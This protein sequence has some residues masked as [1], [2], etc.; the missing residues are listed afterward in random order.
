MV[1]GL[2]LVVGLAAW[3]VVV[4]RPPADPWPMGA[5]LLGVTGTVLIAYLTTREWPLVV[6]VLVAVSPLVAIVGYGRSPFGEGPLGYGNASGTL[7]LLAAAGALT[8]ARSVTQRSLRVVLHVAAG[9]WMVSPLAVM[10]DTAA[11]SAAVM[12]LAVVLLDRPRHVR[13]VLLAGGVLIVLALGATLMYATTYSEGG[14]AGAADR[15]IDAVF[16]QVRPALWHD[17]VQ[18]IRA[19]PVTG[20]GAGR[21]SEV[22]PTASEHSD[23]RGAHNEFL[24]VTAETGVPGGLLLAGSCAWLLTALWKRRVGPRAVAVVVSLLAVMVNA[25]FG[26]VWHAGA[27]PLVMAGLFG[28]IMAPSPP[29]G[30]GPSLAVQADVRRVVVPC[31]LLGVVVATPL[32]PSHAPNTVENAVRWLD[33]GSGIVLAGPGAAISDAPPRALYADLAE[34]DE[35]TV[36]LLVAPHALDQRGPARIVSMSASTGLRN[37]TVGQQDDQVVLRLRTTETNWNGTSPALGVAGV[38]ETTD[39]VHLVVVSDLQE[40][41]VYVDGRLH[42]RGPGPS[43]SMANWIHHYPLVLGNERTGE[44]PWAGRIALLAFYDRALHQP[45]VDQLYR[46]RPERSESGSAARADAL[47]LYTFDEGSGRSIADRS[48]AGAGGALRIPERFPAEVTDQRQALLAFGRPHPAG[49][50]VH[51]VA[52]AAWALVVYPALQRWST[53]TVAGVSARLLTCSFVAG[54]GVLAAMVSSSLRGP[55]PGLRPSVW[56]LGAAALGVLV[57]CILAGRTWTTRGRMRHR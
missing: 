1:T 3:S 23:T 53:R 57:G 7:Y 36:E 43:G 51:V 4:S 2:A 55:Q 56:D 40:S 13:G 34:S 52:F 8:A 46:T 41:R 11:I 16:G 47:A 15:A 25:A 38:F 21:F 10:A 45:E 54:G 26:H 48:E 19:E 6:P 29:T 28:A 9:V 44:R 17:A 35:L 37:L 14:R 30:G 39:P 32:A 33:K 27:I 12:V 24:Q 49:L 42:H 5:L 50:F 22:S 18:M 20:V 31:V